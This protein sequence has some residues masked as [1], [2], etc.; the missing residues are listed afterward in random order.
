MNVNLWDTREHALDY[1]QRRENSIPHRTEGEAAMLEHFPAK[2]SRILDIGTGAG[3]LIGIAKQRWPQ[4][5]AVGVDFSPMMLELSRTRFAGDS[6]VT[7]IEHNLDKPLLNL[8]VFDVVMSSFAI[9]HVSHERK[10]S[11]YVEVFNM[12]V[13]GGVFCNLEHVSSPSEGLHHKFLK[14]MDIAAENDDPSNKLLDVETQ[15]SWLREIG[16]TDVDC[17]WKWRELALLAGWRPG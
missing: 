9:H 4:V 6:A 16:F 12:L 10:R 1:I 7:I 17:H 2:A 8:G 14:S 13:P 3:R 5:E 11:L 15:L